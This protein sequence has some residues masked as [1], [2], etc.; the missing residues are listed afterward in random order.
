MAGSYAVKAESETS[1]GTW[2]AKPAPSDKPASPRTLDFNPTDFHR[3][4]SADV[5]PELHRVAGGN[6]LTGPFY[7]EGAMP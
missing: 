1:T 4:L 6:P 5:K 2:S 7:V 3:R